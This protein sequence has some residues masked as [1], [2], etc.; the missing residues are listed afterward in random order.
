MLT[1]DWQAQPEGFLKWMFVSLLSGEH[2][3]IKQLSEPTDHFTNVILTMQINEVEVDT[4]GFIE[5]LERNITYKAK[6][7]AKELVRKP[8][9]EL[10]PD[11]QLL[12][13][14]IQA[15]EHAIRNAIQAKLK[16]AGIKIDLHE[17]Y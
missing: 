14:T 6:D 5:S 17:E 11:L 1:F 15:A 8:L 9:D 12:Q 2:D 4:A 10:V 7:A 3:L 16:A 13:E